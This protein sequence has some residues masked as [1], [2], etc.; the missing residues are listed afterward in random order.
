MPQGY[1]DTEI[2]MVLISSNVY[3]SFLTKSV[4]VVV[5]NPQD[6]NSVQFNLLVMLADNQICHFKSLIILKSNLGVDR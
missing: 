2:Y 4:S 3:F 1:R 6:L 5:T